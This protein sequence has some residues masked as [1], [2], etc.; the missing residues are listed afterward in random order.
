[1][2]RKGGGS[3]VSVG[4]LGS[5]VVGLALV[6]GLDEGLREGG[7]GGAAIELSLGLEGLPAPR[8]LPQLAQGACAASRSPRRA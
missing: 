6:A 2:K 3:S 4:V 1:M 5:K 8:R 7:V